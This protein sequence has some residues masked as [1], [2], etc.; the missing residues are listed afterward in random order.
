MIYWIWL[1]RIPG[2]GPVLQ[3]E[4][5]RVFKTP[6]DVFQACGKELINC[7]GLGKEKEKIIE[8]AKSNPK[9]LEACKKISMNL[10]KHNIKLLTNDDPLYP[11][12]AKELHDSPVLLYYKGTIRN[13]SMGVGI[14]GA[15]RCTSYGDRKSVV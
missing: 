4:L 12:K 9:I 5:L 1:T 6:E 10:E 13:K 14:V 8:E 2:I 15:R 11:S 7:N 3:K